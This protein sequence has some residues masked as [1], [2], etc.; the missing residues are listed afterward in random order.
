MMIIGAIKT[1]GVINLHKEFH[2]NK[3]KTQD[4]KTLKSHQQYQVGMFKNY[5]IK[6]HP[7]K[8]MMMMDGEIVNG[9]MIRNNNKI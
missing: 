1:N 8:K 9:N 7:C 6:Q 4:V 2:T 3:D 5:I